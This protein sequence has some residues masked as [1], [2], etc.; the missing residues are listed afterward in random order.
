VEEAD[1]GLAQRD[2]QGNGITVDGPAV[3]ATVCQASQTARF[4]T[5]RL[6][7]D[8]TIDYSPYD[9]HVLQYGEIECIQ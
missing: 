7:Y 5:A 2:S 3:G 9:S 6:V 1:P 4:P 8:V